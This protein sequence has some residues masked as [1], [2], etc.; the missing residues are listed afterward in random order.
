MSSAIRKRPSRGL[1]LWR[2]SVRIPSPVPGSIGKFEHFW[3]NTNN[4]DLVSCEGH[5]WGEGTAGTHY[6]IWQVINKRAPLDAKSRILDW[7]AGANKMLIGHKYFAKLQRGQSV[8][9]IVAVEKDPA[10]FAKG[11]ANLKQAG[12]Q[13]GTPDCVTI[14]CDSTCIPSWR[15]ITHVLLYD[16]GPRHATTIQEYHQTIMTNVFATDSVQC[17]FSTQLTPALFRAYFGT[18]YDWKWSVYILDGMNW[19]GSSYQG[20]L[21]VK[22]KC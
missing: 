11:L 8:A 15:G 18:V 1:P 10:T 13:P 16:G 20:Y 7:G 12:F 22:R 3:R 21:Y 4:P 17:V 19:G 5:A 14:N 6:K 9:P 2:E